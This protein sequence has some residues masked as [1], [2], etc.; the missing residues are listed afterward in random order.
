[1]LV[2]VVIAAVAESLRISETTM[3]TRSV[4]LLSLC[5]SSKE[6]LSTPCSPVQPQCF[7]TSM[8]IR[9]PGMLQTAIFSVAFI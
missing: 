5:F 1:M 4:S 3:S 8:P 7:L 6:I 2:V 9:T